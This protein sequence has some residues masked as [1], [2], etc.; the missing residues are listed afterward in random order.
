MRS[1]GT[2]CVAQRVW[3]MPIL[4]EV[5]VC[6]SAYLS[7]QMVVKIRSLCVNCVNVSALNLL[8]LVWVL[9]GI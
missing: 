4:P 5:G 6:A 8:I 1:L 3:A 9:L 7:Y 2:P